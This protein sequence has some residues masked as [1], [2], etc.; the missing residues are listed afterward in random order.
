MSPIQISREQAIDLVDGN[1]F[2]LHQVGFFL[3]N[4]SLE[5]IFSNLETTYFDITDEL[6]G[7]ISS[8]YEHWNAPTI[9]SLEEKSDVCPASLTIASCDETCSIPVYDLGVAS[10]EIDILL[11]LIPTIG[12]DSYPIEPDV[13]EKIWADACAYMRCR[14]LGLLSSYF[15][16]SPDGMTPDWFFSALTRIID[17]EAE[18]LTVV[19]TGLGVDNLYSVT[20]WDEFWNGLEDHEGPVHRTTW[21]TS[22]R[23]EVLNRDIHNDL[24]SFWLVD[25]DGHEHFRASSNS[26]EEVK[27]FLL[28]QGWSYTETTESSTTSV[29]SNN[30]FGRVY[31][32]VNINTNYERSPAVSPTPHVQPTQQRPGAAVESGIIS[33][34]VNISG[35]AQINGIVQGDVSVPSGSDVNLNGIVQGTVWVNGGT[36]RLFGTISAAAISSGRIEIY[37]ILQSPLQYNGGDVYFHPNSIIG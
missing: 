11:A 19:F 12:D 18:Q 6:I 16:R 25:E 23:I 10:R 2:S 3:T 34:N 28:A 17:D 4:G 22:S 35:L 33:G 24:V 15:A 37:G 8:S 20:C 31:G 26:F 32:E 27:Q 1:R 5:Q 14:A 13:Q 7:K 21:T 30:N 9:I 36:A 29:A